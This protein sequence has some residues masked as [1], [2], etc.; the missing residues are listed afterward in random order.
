MLATVYTTS[1]A[2]LPISR[3]SR[4]QGLF[5]LT[6]FDFSSATISFHGLSPSG[7]YFRSTLPF[8]TLF[9]RSSNL[10]FPWRQTGNIAGSFLQPNT[11]YELF[12]G[13]SF[14]NRE[15][16]TWQLYTGGSIP[17]WQVISCSCGTSV[18]LVRSQSHRSHFIFSRQ[19]WTTSF[20]TCR[21]WVNN[22]ELSCFWWSTSKVYGWIP[23]R[24]D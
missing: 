1:L 18:R 3:I 12:G 13:Q 17:L 11:F 5:L 2:V 7:S 10:D 4:Q 20:S 23:Q 19:P 14:P 21:T 24:A 16:L 6:S 9:P 15:V 22:I 8:K